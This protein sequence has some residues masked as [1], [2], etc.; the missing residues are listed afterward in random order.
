MRILF[1]AVILLLIFSAILPV[2]AEPIP[3]WLE[4][5]Q[6]YHGLEVPGGENF[7]AWFQPVPFAS[8]TITVWMHTSVGWFSVQSLDG[9]PNLPTSE[10]D[11]RTFSDDP[12]MIVTIPILAR[13]SLPISVEF[14]PETSEAYTVDI[15]VVG[16]VPATTLEDACFNSSEGLQP[17]IIY[18]DLADQQ[19]GDDWYEPINA[20]AGCDYRVTV[21]TETNQEWFRVYGPGPEYAFVTEPQFPIVENGYMY[22]ASFRAEESG[23]YT[24]SV[25]TQTPGVM[26]PFTLEVSAIF[27]VPTEP[28]DLERPL[29]EGIWYEQWDL[30]D[31]AC[32]PVREHNP[33]DESFELSYNESG[34]IVIEYLSSGYTVEFLPSEN[35]DGTFVMPSARNQPMYP[36]P[37][38]TVQPINAET[39]TLKLIDM[40]GGGPDNHCPEYTLF[41][42][43]TLTQPK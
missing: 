31:Y 43:W 25:Y 19:G 17:G 4:I 18:E 33:T 26:I 7:V 41:A 39:A 11:I 5:N 16:Q 6:E 35:G 40:L 15:K 32:G 29:A 12:G 38:F 36:E 34:S 10:M 24:V 27:Q 3:E 21:R 14:W 28:M 9:R 1:S 30:S 23:A 37:I 22:T 2:A 20:T 13:N 8:Y 42:D